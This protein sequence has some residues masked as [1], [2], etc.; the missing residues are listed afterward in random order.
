MERPLVVDIKRGAVDDGPGIRTVVFFKGC[1]LSCQWCHNPESIDPGREI[2]FYPRECI[3]CGDCEKAC[4]RAACRLENPA[5]IERSVCNRCGLCADAC[6]AHALRSIGQYYSPDVLAHLLEKDLPLYRASG[7]GVTLSGGEATIHMDYLGAILRQLKTRSMHIVLQTNGFFSWPRFEKSI[8]PYID[9]VMM[10]VK[11]ADP[12]S[13]REH[14]G[15]SN[16]TILDNLHRMAKDHPSRLL[17]RIPLIPGFTA[18]IGNLEGLGSLFARL[19]IENHV[20]LPYN[21]TWFDKARAIGKGIEGA[22]PSQIP[23]KADALS[24]KEAFDTAHGS[25][26]P[27]SEQP[28]KGAM[29]NNWR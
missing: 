7:G 25:G 16:E 24:W 14:T 8:L 17:P 27:G 11:L 21:P 9:L 18:T 22:L 12:V 10:D 6:S 23:S 19:H 26:G 20:F 13:H 15:A 4:V 1:N 3:A 2:G 28:Q 5:R 29:M